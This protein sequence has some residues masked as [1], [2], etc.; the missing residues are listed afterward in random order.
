MTHLPLILSILLSALPLAATARGAQGPA[1]YVNPFV[2]T[3]NY[4]ATHPGALCPNGMMHVVPFNAIGTANGNKDKDLRWWSTGYEHTNSLFTG[5]AHTALSGVGC[6]EMGALLVMPTTGPLDVDCRRYASTYAEEQA[7]PGYYANRLTRYGIGTEATATVRTGRLRLHFPPGR[8]NLLLNLGESLSNESGATMRFTPNGE[9]EGMRMLGS[10]CYNQQAV[11]PVYFVMRVS[12]VPQQRGYWKRMPPMGVEAQWDST[13][14]KRKIYTSYTGPISGDDIGAWL[15]W[16]SDTAH[17]VEVSMGISFVSVDNARLNLDAEQQGLSFDDMRS[18]AFEAWNRDLSRIQVEG[19]TPEQRRVFYTALYHTLIHPGVVSDVN[20]QYPAMESP[21][22]LTSQHPRYTVFSLWDTYRNVHQLLTL[23]YP[24]RQVDMVRSM[25]G[26]YNEHG[27]LPRWELFGRET[28]TMEGDPATPVIVDTW[29]KGLGGFDINLAYQAMMKAATTP[30]GRNLLRPDNSDYMRLGYVP[31]RDEFDNSVSHALEY[32]VAD[33]AL[34]T[35][36]AQ[37]GHK[38]DAKML[39]ERARGYRH[40]YSEQTG[41]MRPL[42]PDGRFLTPFNPETGKNF[43]PCPGFHEG[44][45]WAYTFYV[46]HDIQGLARLMGGRATFVSRLQSVFDRGLFDPANE[47]DMA[48]PYLFSQ[49]RGEEWRTQR[50][51]RQLLERHFTDT[52]G[53]LPGNDDTGTMSCWALFSMMGLY[54]DCPGV[55][56][57]TLTAPVFDSIT[58]CLDTRY[59]GSSSLK[60]TTQPAPGQAPGG[61]YVKSVTINGHPVKGMRISHDMIRNGGEMR[62]VTT[63]RH[64]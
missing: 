41:T 28:L 59:Y 11:F 8:A 19:G 45:A 33:H 53:G 31:L 22:T 16:Q 64:P 43:E 17:V 20:G 56:Q 7:S 61:P 38:A 10:F 52:P 29:M 62:F 35:L 3:T 9:V 2:G 34:A 37:L 1:C 13:A 23:V 25:L 57:Y 5:Y 18:A 54:P 39:M 49:F 4:G 47:P 32:Y 26:M 42:L 15:S 58:I 55:P 51:V 24:E 14:G 40:Y 50:L 46:P 63:H 6:P 36:A 48:Y 27:W 21:L 12:K 30:G 60:I 44:S